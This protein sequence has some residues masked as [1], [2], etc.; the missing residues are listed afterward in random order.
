MFCKHC[1]SLRKI[2]K[3][4]FGGFHPHTFSNGPTVV[5]LHYS[6]KMCM[7]CQKIVRPRDVS[8][9]SIIPHMSTWCRPSCLAPG[10]SHAIILGQFIGVF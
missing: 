8:C 2:L 3:M 5:Q 4:A 10:F 9:M 6:F 1:H 7:D